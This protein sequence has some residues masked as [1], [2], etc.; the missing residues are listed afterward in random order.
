MD[1]T[2]KRIAQAREACNLPGLA[3]VAD[4]LRAG[5]ALL[6]AQ[7]QAPLV[8]KM[9]PSRPGAW[10]VGQGD[11][12]RQVVATERG[13]LAAWYAC[14]SKD[15][16]PLADHCQSDEKDPGRGL[17]QSIQGACAAAVRSYCPHLAAVFESQIRIRGG[18]L[19]YTGPR[20]IDC[21]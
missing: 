17:K 6:D 5:L 18:R 19:V 10:I 9:D 14:Q 3:H 7:Q 11:R 21:D 13:M 15:G 12:V 8:F 20:P 2:L 1:D 4:L 16:T